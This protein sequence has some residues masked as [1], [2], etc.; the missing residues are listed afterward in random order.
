LQTQSCKAKAVKKPLPNKPD[1]KF[2]CE[3][4][5]LKQAIKK[6]ALQKYYK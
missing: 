5:T 1:L 6:E 4:K 3:A 2:A